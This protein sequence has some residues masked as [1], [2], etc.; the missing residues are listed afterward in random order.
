MSGAIVASLDR[1]AIEDGVI[2]P[3][4]VGDVVEAVLEL[5][6][7]EAPV[8]AVDE[9]DD[10]GTDSST[11][12]ARIIGSPVGDPGL[13][14]DRAW[15]IRSGEVYLLPVALDLPPRPKA[16]RVAAVGYVRFSWGPSAIGKL[17][18]ASHRWRIVRIYA[19]GA[20]GPS[21]SVKSIQKWSDKA[22]EEINQ[23]LVWLTLD[24]PQ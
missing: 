19:I 6:M 1:I 17:S 7:S 8:P 5:F 2:A 18:Q 10:I 24:S 11:A 16:E 22:S 12:Q 4:S 9:G 15:L 14:T 3:F 21:A 23:Y 13:P 20:G